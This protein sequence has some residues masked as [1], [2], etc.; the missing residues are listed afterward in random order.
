M[1]N[2]Y[3]HNIIISNDW[4]HNN[5]FKRKKIISYE[6]KK[7]GNNKDNTVVNRILVNQTKKI[8]D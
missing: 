5:N 4:L 8:L 2:N 1:I 7:D 6:Y 3:V